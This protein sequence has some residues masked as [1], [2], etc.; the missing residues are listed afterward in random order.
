MGGK[1]ASAPAM[2]KPAT[3]R[4]RQEMASS[5]ISIERAWWRIA[6]SSWRTTIL[7]PARR[8]PLLEALLHR[9]DHLV[10][11][12]PAADVLLGGVAHLGVDHA[13]G[14]QVLDALT[15]DAGD[16]RDRSA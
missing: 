5:A 16:R 15:R 14:G 10:E 8:H 2:S 11:G 12:H 3:P 1:P 7:P 13:V 6:V 4:S 9:S